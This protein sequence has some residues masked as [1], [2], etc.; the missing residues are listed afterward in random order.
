MAMNQTCYGVRGKDSLGQFSLYCLLKSEVAK[1]QSMVHGTIF[2][3]ITRDTFSRILTTEPPSILLKRSESI[4]AS[5]FEMA[6]SNQIENKTLAELRDTLLPR[7][8]SGKL[9]ISD[10]EKLLAK[11][12]V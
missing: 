8:I 4:I 2:D 12:P 6:L 9:R 3:T 11:A 1:L 5:M 7:L 10:A